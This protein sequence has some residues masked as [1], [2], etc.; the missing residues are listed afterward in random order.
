MLDEHGFGHHGTGAA[1]TGEPGDGRQQMQKQDGQ[2]AHRTILA[3]SRHAEMLRNFGIRHAH[4]S[5]CSQDGP[6]N[7][8]VATTLGTGVDRNSLRGPGLLTVD[9]AVSKNVGLAGDAYLQLRTEVFNLFNRA[10]YGL[11]NAAIFIA[12]AGGGAAYNANAGQITSAGAP[13]QMQLGA[14]LVF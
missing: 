6:T 7:L 2:I 3:R 5:E 1:G 11:P 14:K 10:N 4:L 13:R 12:T 9:F 8:S